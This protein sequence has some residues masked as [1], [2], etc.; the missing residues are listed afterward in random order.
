VLHRTTKAGLGPAYVA[1]FS[2]ATERGYAVVVEMD[3]DGSHPPE[4]LPALLHALRDADLVLGSR[5]VPGGSVVDW[6][7]HRLV[8]S[9]V[10]NLY[11][12]WALRLP[13]T[14]ATG[15]FR[16]ARTELI[17]RLPFD[18]VSSQGYCFQV[19]WAW[20]ADRAGARVV[21]VPIAFSERTAG[22]SKMGA[23]IVGEAL[24]RVTWWGILDRL[25]DWLPGRVTR[26]VPGR[27]RGGR[28]TRA[29]R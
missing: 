24:A 19:D 6:P 11:T 20:R 4:R 14:D 28:R 2:W 10:G 13:L 7:A 1:G 26:P 5:Y 18:S 9:R 12:R 23:S 16:A 3:A 27:A 21:E 25:A 8:L 17:S 29:L 15:G 22:R